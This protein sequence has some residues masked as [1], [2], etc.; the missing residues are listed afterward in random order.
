MK[1][2]RIVIAITVPLFLATGLWLV[3][4]D[5]RHGNIGP[6]GQSGLAAAE[7]QRGEDDVVVRRMWEGAEPDFWSAS[8]SPDGRFVSE[9]DWISG[10]LAVL[11]LHE[12]ALSPITHGTWAER[13]EW[14]ETS[15]F[16]PDGSR[17][18]YTW[19]SQDVGG[20]EIRSIHRD[21]TEVRT[22][23]PNPDNE[24]YAMVDSWSPDGRWLLAR[25][26]TGDADRLA[27]I[28][29]EDGSTRPLAA[30]PDWG[31]EQ[32]ATFSPD[33][34]FVAF[35]QPARQQADEFDIMVI[36]VE[37]GRSSTLV[38][39]SSD[40]RL[41]GWSP[42]GG[43][44]FYSDRD[45]SEGFWWQPVE[46]GVASGEP[47][48][49]KS[50]VWRA[51]PI[52]FARDGRFFY[53]VTTE[54]RQVHTAGI[55][56]KANRMTTP[57]APVEDP[58]RGTTSHGTWSPDG[59]YLAYEHVLPGVRR[60]H[61]VLRS[62]AG[63]GRQVI[64]FEGRIDRLYWFDDPQRLLARATTW[65]P[66]DGWSLYRVD[67]QA[68]DV[69]VLFVQDD[70]NPVMGEIG[71]DGRTLFYQPDPIGMAE[72]RILVRDLA[73]GG[74]REVARI[75]GSGLLR[76]SPDGAHLA[77][78]A[79]ERETRT[80]RLL[81]VSVS[82]GEVVELHRETDPNG[83]TVLNWTPDGRYVLFST[84]DGSAGISGLW[85]IPGDGGEPVA[86]TGAPQELRFLSVHPEGNRVAFSAGEARGEVWVVE[87]L[88]GAGGR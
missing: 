87:G 46:D 70:W 71:P 72:N 19:W 68:G 6:V 15:V 47:H 83:L 5:L 56:L 22:I 67:P 3:A 35:D 30:V 27:L 63:D 85:K 59:R 25:L 14:A 80:T 53:G 37:S 23:L 33:G 10:N 52:G 64:P 40:D 12:G 73:N 55:D 34:R 32:N 39:G 7:S 51:E 75:D 41:M 49:V 74:D 69:D 11:D 42:D 84:W 17:L 58:A 28:S 26:W 81:V 61:I 62:T 45:L 86:I 21:G 18:A 48:L 4:T 66:G 2:A 24:F 79:W 29:V 43:I 82:D 65:G 31:E 9:I 20:Y 50:N 54:Q 13:T 36:D 88:P 44:L 76:P 60:R 8:I 1:Q 78:G 57:P 38:G 77:I 16:A